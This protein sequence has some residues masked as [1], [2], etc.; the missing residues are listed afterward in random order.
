MKNCDILIS[1]VIKIDSIDV[2]NNAAV[3]IENNIIIDVG[4]SDDFTSKYQAKYTI[5]GSNKIIMPGL[6]NTHTHA[7]AALFRGYASDVSGRSGL[8]FHVRFFLG[9]RVRGGRSIDRLFHED[10]HDVSHLETIAPL[11]D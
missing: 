2:K 6:I 10:G 5:D 8:R 1:D 4:N 7:S 11:G 9:V 3:A